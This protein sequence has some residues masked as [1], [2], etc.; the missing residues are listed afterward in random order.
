MITCPKCG[1]C[2]ISGPYYR[3]G[4]HGSEWLEYQCSKCGYTESR[5]TLDTDDKDPA[6][7]S[8]GRRGGLK[9][10]PVRA[11]SLTPERRA[12]IARKAAQTRWRTDGPMTNRPCSTGETP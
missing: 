7:V 4:K 9:G 2:N 8:L 12:E 3:S 5:P 6:A 1:G 11:A 10:G